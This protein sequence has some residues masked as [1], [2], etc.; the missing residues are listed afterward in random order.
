MISSYHQHTRFD[1]IKIKIKIKNIYYARAERQTAANRI[2]TQ[3]EAEQVDLFGF[4]GS[5]T[6]SYHIFYHLFFQ[7]TTLP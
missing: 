5:P 4:Q 3:N 6:V 2:G 1:D 7:Y